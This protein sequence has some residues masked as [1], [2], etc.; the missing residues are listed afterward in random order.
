MRSFWTTD[1]AMDIGL[2]TT[3]VIVKGR[4]IVFS[5]STEDLRAS[6]GASS[7]SDLISACLERA[8]IRRGWFRPA[9]R[10]VLTCR[11]CIGGAEKQRLQEAA[12]MAGAKAI[13]LIELPMAC[14]IGAGLPV[15]MPRGSMVIDVRGGGCD[16]AVISL[17]GIVASR[18]L[19]RSVMTSAAKDA[20]P[21][22]VH[23]EPVS[24][25]MIA[26]AIKDILAECGAKGLKNLVSDVLVGGAVVAGD[27]G[28][29]E[30]LA[31]WLAEKAGL[32]VR[33]AHNPVTAAVEG[34]GVVLKE[35]DFLA[36]SLRA[37]T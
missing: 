36:M 25:E 22:C 14:A 29:D 13:F 21:R 2:E 28:A 32:P 6:S 18:S 19:C 24:R 1:V 37:K 7:I 12:T 30:S 11:P 3:H 35:L 20:E 10:V 5:G 15:S 33:V 31:N 8:G 4:G 17:A 26:G 34:A 23:G 9:I 27:D 16:V